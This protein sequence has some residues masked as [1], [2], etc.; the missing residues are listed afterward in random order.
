MWGVTD[1]ETYLVGLILIVLLPGPN[2]LF[3][4]TVAA[5]DGVRRGYAAASGVFLGDA[6]L[7]F[8]SAVGVAS[9]LQANQV[10]FTIVK[11]LGAGYLGWLALGLLRA[12]WAQW[13]A[14]DRG[15]ETA[16]LADDAAALVVQQPEAHVASDG[17]SRSPAGSA[18]RRALVISLVN[19]KAI[20]FF[21]AFFVQF[22]DPA[23]PEP[24]I[25]FLILAALLEIASFLYLSA[26]IFAGAQLAAVFRKRRALSAGGTSVVGAVFLGFAVKLAT[27]SA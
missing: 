15:A 4:L 22:V 13:R 21:V 18:F 7:M 10:L 6:V 16:T 20:L 2:S 8:L 14:G 27:A 3:V 12:A 25:P 1:I 24:A 5:R 17:E 26:L 9:V 23:Y 19:P 11:Y